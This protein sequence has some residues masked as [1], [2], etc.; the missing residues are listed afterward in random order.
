MKLRWLVLVLQAI[1]QLPKSTASPTSTSSP[2]ST[3][4]F[5]GTPNDAFWYD[6]GRYGLHPEQHYESFSASPPRPYL[7]QHDKRCSATVTDDDNVDGQDLIFAAPRGLAVTAPGP[8]VYDTRGHLVWMDT[9]WGEA[10][11]VKVQQYNGED[12]LTFWHGTDNGTFGEGQYYM[13]N[14]SYDVVRTVKPAPTADGTQLLGDLHDFVIT[15]AGTALMTIYQTRPRDLTQKYGIQSGW[16]FDSL[17]QEVDIA[18]GKLIFQWRASDHFAVEDTFAPLKRGFGKHAAKAFDFFHINSVAKMPTSGDYIVSSRYM[19]AV[20]CVSGTTGDVLWQ[21]GGRRN[22]FKDLSD[23]QATNTHWQHHAVWHEETQELSVF[24]NGAYDKLETAEYSRGMRIKLGLDSKPPTAELVRAYV[25]PQKLLAQS[26]G[27]VQLL[28]ATDT[29]LVGW[30]HIPAYTEFDTI[31]GT[32][33]CDVHL[34]PLGFAALGWCKNYRTAKHHWVGSPSTLP[35][36]AMR[37]DEQAVYVSWNGATEVRSWQLQIKADGNSDFVNHG[38]PVVKNDFESRLD[39]SSTAKMVRVAALDRSGQVLAYSEAVSTTETTVVAA[40]AAPPPKETLR[41]HLL[42]LALY[43][44]LGVAGGCVLAYL[45]LFRYRAATF[46]HVRRIVTS[47]VAT[48]SRVLP[49]RRSYRYEALPTATPVMTEVVEMSMDG[50][51]GGER[52]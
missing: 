23:G 51:S 42:R 1:G 14:A 32:P 17:F 37:P 45:V 36:I 33:L 4:P 24:D 27:S 50:R 3:G 22:S 10:M 40:M 35:S 34:C 2:S 47:V 49:S 26:Q 7:L 5:F 15:E 18:T 44:S 21:L 11:D 41:G 30:G 39:V 25:A 48:V 13:L 38:S 46:A 12:Y 43:I 28:P 19:C 52:G 6:W 29:V 9:R 20:I 8:I 31:T 16:I